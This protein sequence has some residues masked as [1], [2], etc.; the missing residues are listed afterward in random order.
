M[1]DLLLLRSL[2][3]ISGRI[4][5]ATRGLP[6]VGIYACHTPVLF[7][8]DLDLVVRMC[9]RDFDHFEDRGFH[10]N[11]GDS[12][13]RNLIHQNGRDWRFS[14][15]KLSPCF[16]IARVKSMFP[17]MLRKSEDLVEKFKKELVLKDRV[18]VWDVSL[19][20]TTDVLAHCMMGVEAQSLRDREEFR[21][22][23]KHMLG[24]RFIYHIFTGC[25][26]PGLHRLFRIAVAKSCVTRFFH[27]IVQQVMDHRKDTS[28]EKKDV[29][30]A[31]IELKDE[32][33]TRSSDVQM[34]EIDNNFIVAQ[35]FGFFLAGYETPGNTLACSLFEVAKQPAIQQALYEEINRVLSKY[36][37]EVT[38]DALQD[39]KYLRQIVTETL[40]KYTPLTLIFRRCTKDYTI[41]DTSTVIQK[42]TLVLIPLK[43]IH[44]DPDYHPDP[45]TFDPERFSEE[46]TASRHMAA[47]MPFGIGPR[48]C[49]AVLYSHIEI[50]T[51][52]VYLLRQFE[53]CVTTDTPAYLQPSPL[54]FLMVPKNGIPL[55]F[56]SRQS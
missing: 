18:E 42:G 4:Y 48:F 29:I 41:P 6:Y 27:Q 49:P 55:A 3:D 47:Y 21:E 44:E 34:P 54:D 56:K 53:V 31:L 11:S 39:M 5:E 28:S 13:G 37:G 10:S 2:P 43:S 30:Q 8:R 24:V 50:R 32:F 15:S 16:N 35:T 1:Y 38:F 46:N 7:V 51:A 40:R 23:S 9:V 26:F 17:T 20:Y 14:R 12:L 19:R 45:A 22:I 25:F 33:E 52:L 36:D